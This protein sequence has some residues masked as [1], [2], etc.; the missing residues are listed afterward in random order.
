LIGEI[1]SKCEKHLFR[2]FVRGAYIHQGP[3]C[4]PNGIVSRND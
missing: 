3:D 1:L 2:V 4:I